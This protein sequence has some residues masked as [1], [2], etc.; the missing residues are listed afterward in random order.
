M[1]CSDADLFILFNVS[2]LKSGRS[3]MVLWKNYREFLA[4]LVY[5]IWKLDYHAL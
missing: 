1:V 3:Q 5:D 4:T 2:G